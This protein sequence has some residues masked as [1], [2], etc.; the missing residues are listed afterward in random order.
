MKYQI[1]QL[2]RD[3]Y[4]GTVGTITSAVCDDCGFNI[5][6]VYPP[7]PYD[8][9]VCNDARLEEEIALVDEKDAGFVTAWDIVY[10]SVMKAIDHVPNV[11]GN[12]K[13]DLAETVLAHIVA[14]RFD[15]RS[16]FPDKDDNFASLL[17]LF[18]K[19]ARDCLSFDPLMT[20]CDQEAG[21]PLRA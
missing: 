6:N 13:L 15:E 11:E 20:S 10:R 4:T 5:Y 14:K 18:A 7:F 21:S 3:Q 1:G 19:E 16:R 12:P 9:G 2:V 8:H 17:E